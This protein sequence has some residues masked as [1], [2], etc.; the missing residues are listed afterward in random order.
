MP[1][2]HRFPMQKYK[3]VREALLQ[4][5]ILSQSQLKPSPLASFQE[6]ELA[7]THDYVQ[8]FFDGTVDTRIIKRIGFPWNLELLNRSRATVGGALSAAQSA[9]QFG[10]SGNLA[11][12][13]HHAHAGGGEGYCVFNDFAVVC[14]SLLQNQ[15]QMRIAIVDLDVH[16]GNGNSSILGG[17][18]QIYI[19]SLHGARNY[20][21]VKVPSTVDIAL[22]DHTTDSVYIAA[23]E[24]A[25]EGVWSFQPELVLYQAG[26]DPLIHDRLGKLDISFEGLML[27]D[28]IVLR[29]CKQRNIP[30]SLALGGGYSEPIDYSVKA[31]VNTYRVVRE[32][33][34]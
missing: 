13:T 1:D 33:F 9:L 32:I 12:G 30:I 31:Y 34:G 19:L 22:P 7:H 26:V 3:L 5:G 6:L 8:S 21:Y 20:P 28:R 15:Q 10:V 25:I 23:L 18:P 16:Q 29:G 24:E 27:R 11:G 14:R 17:D 2:G 4:E